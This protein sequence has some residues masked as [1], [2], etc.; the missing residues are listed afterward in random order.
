MITCR[1]DWDIR[2]YHFCDSIDLSLF[3]DETV[4][5]NDVTNGLN[6][7]LSQSDEKKDSGLSQTPYP[8]ST[9]SSVSFIHLS[10]QLSQD[11]QQGSKNTQAEQIENN[12]QTNELILSTKQPVPIITQLAPSYNSDPSIPRLHYPYQSN[13]D[14]LF[15][16]ED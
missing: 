6:P 10:S 14:W 4:K 9:S 1:G 11:N 3:S 12:K 8:L 2:V 13:W 5:A 15:S 16:R 7:F